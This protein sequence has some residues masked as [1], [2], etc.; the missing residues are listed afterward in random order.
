MND[1]RMDTALGDR[2]ALVTGGASGLGLATAETL[3]AAGMAVAV[4]DIAIERATDVASSIRSAG[5]RAV[6]VALD[7]TRAS[8][9]ADAVAAT[10]AAFGGL[11]VLVNCAGTDVTGDFEAVDAAA[12]E[13]IVDV[14]LLGPARLT[15]AAL[16][17]LRQSRAAHVVNVASTAALRGWPEASAY[18]ASKWGLRGLGMG[19]FSDLRRHGI[20]VTTLYAG[21]MRT[22]FILDRFPDTPLDNLQDPCTVAE[23]IRFV[24]SVPSGSVVAELLVVPMRETSWP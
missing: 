14:N 11:D 6:P 13:H 12:W 19:L 8:S 20:R 7:V 3:A 16:P 15:R 22:P 21:G 5:G 4:A 10:S 9:A 1:V 17:A 2:I 24:L 18:H 23:T